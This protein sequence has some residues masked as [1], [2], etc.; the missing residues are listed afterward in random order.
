MKRWY[1]GGRRC[2]RG[3]VPDDFVRFR[4]SLEELDGA[5]DA[6][7]KAG[8]QFVALLGG[9][10]SRHRLVDTIL[11]LYPEADP[12]MLRVARARDGCTMLRLQH[13]DR[14]LYRVFQQDYRNPRRRSS[15]I[16]SRTSRRGPSPGST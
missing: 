13:R 6:L 7:R 16:W 5:V 12:P 10:R 4:R 14:A 3:R 1:L 11:R 15:S 2:W 8:L 9:D